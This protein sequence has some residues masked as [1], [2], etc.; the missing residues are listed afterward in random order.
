MF[1]VAKLVLTE[2]QRALLKKP[3]GELVTGTTSECNRRLKE[4]QETERPRLLILVGDSITKNALESGISP[5]VII[6]DRLEKR[7]EAA[8]FESGKV[9]VFRARNEPGG[10][11]LLAWNAIAEAIEQ[12]NSMVIVDGEEDL[13]TLAAI[14]AAPPNSVVAYGQ[15]DEGIVLVRVSDQ[16]K[17]EISRIIDGMQRR[18]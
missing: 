9:R 18:D 8:E 17:D 10:I 11:D 13:L 14:I 16:K 15:P 7:K 12:G 6:I 5:D 4:V 2:D 1:L 3:L